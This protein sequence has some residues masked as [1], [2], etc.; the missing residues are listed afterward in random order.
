MTE[1]A[2]PNAATVGAGPLAGLRVVEVSAFVAAPLGGMTLAQLGADVIRIDPIGGN[3]DIN[4]W[5]LAPSGD[6]LYWAG[7][8]K[9]KKS[10][11][12]ALDSKEGQEIAQSLICADGDAA[13]ILLT[14]LPAKGWMSYEALQVRR[15]DLIMLRLT[16][17]YD[18]SSAVDY[19]INC[20]GGFPMATGRGNEPVNHVLPAWDVAA[21]LYIAVGLLA[22]E[23]RRRQTGAGQEI[24]IA[25]S[26]V[27]LATISALGYIAEVQINGTVRPPMGNDLYGAYGRDF[28]TA[29]GRRVMI[30]A[31]SNRQWRAIGKATGLA[32]RFALIG[33]A[34]GVDLGDESGRFEAREAIS[35]LLARWC[36]RQTLAEIA[37][38][39]DGAGVLWGPYQDFGQLVREDPRCSTKN[40][41]FRD[42]EQP[43]IGRHLAAASPLTFAGMDRVPGAAPRLGQHT[44]SVLSDI[45]GKSAAEIRRLRGAGVLAAREGE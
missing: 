5:P 21:G 40:P 29:D 45:L 2:S 3:I 17:N 38:A 1:A 43:G 25:L 24:S 31:I 4:R 39:F 44:D 37:T 42:L 8:N 26:D 23:R 20:A 35:A 34:M 18:G 7:L 11:T 41:L 13:G 30:A 22:A 6:S 28:T 36:G 10:V 19:T 12:L 33:E 32:D 9:A 16:G 15:P 27:M 14:N